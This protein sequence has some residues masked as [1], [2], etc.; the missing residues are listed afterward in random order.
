[1]NNSEL[2]PNLLKSFTEI[3]ILGLTAYIQK[4][5]NNEDN[6]DENE[7]SED[8][9]YK[10]GLPYTSTS[11]FAALWNTNFNGTIDYMK[12]VGFSLDKDHAPILILED[13]EENYYYSELKF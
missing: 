10:Y 1:M 7:Q 2:Q 12:V 4:W 6:G 3:E 13:S 8:V 5:Q 11:D 9:N